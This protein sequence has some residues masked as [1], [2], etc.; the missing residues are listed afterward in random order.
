MMALWLPALAKP[1]VHLATWTGGGNAR[2]RALC[3]QWVAEYDDR[4]RFTTRP[5]WQGHGGGALVELVDVR[6]VPDG[7]RVCGHCL[8]RY[9]ADDSRLYELLERTGQAD[10]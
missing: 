4:G 2:W 7:M 10:G 9:R 6:H 1:A 5:D 8:R 3:C